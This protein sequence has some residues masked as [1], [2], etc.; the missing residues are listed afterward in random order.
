MFKTLS[1]KIRTKSQRFLFL[2]HVGC[3]GKTG[4]IP[5]GATIF[6]GK[7]FYKLNNIQ[8]RPVISCPLGKPLYIRGKGKNQNK[9]LSK[10]RCRKV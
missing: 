2:N 8:C 6:H 1:T 10:I 9:E 3:K 4:R 7:T 5:A